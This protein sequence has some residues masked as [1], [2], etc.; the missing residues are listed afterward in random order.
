MCK[1]YLKIKIFS[2]IP[3]VITPSQHHTF[4]VKPF[5]ASYSKVDATCTTCKWLFVA[6]NHANYTAIL[7]PTNPDSFPFVP[8]WS[9]AIRILELEGTQKVQYILFWFFLE[10]SRWLNE[11]NIYD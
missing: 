4:L 11:G 8:G 1:L 10:H 2:H 3:H 5:N 9:E 7:T 6:T